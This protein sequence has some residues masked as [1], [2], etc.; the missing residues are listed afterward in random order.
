MKKALIEIGEKIKLVDLIVEILDARAPFST[1]NKYFSSLS[2]S[3]PRIIILNKKDIADLSDFDFNSIKI[4]ENDSVIATNLKSS[5]DYDNILKEIS[6][7]AS[8]RNERYL[9]KGMK[10][11]LL[12]AMIIGIPNVGKSSFI[13]YLAKRNSAP[14]GNIPGYTKNNKW[15]KVSNLFY[16]LDTPGILPPNYD[17]DISKI[18]LA[19]IGSIKQEILPLDFLSNEL[20]D[21]LKTNHINDFNRKYDLKI[22][23]ETQ[24]ELIFAEICRKRGFLLKENNVDIEKAQILL[25]NDFK[26]GRICKVFLDYARIWE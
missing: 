25:L 14:V 17:D 5:D 8:L 18:N 7:V 6:K 4:T 19:L 13:N 20:L 23:K 24:N 1:R 11:Q 2:Q 21:F 15:I 26:N 3:K 10:P 22:G 16:L 12:R 9:K